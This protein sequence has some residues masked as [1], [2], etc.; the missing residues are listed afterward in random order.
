MAN[1]FSGTIL[2]L[3]T[4]LTLL[5][6]ATYYVSSSGDDTNAGTDQDAPWQNCPG[7]P[8][9]SGSA[10][11]Q[12]G[13]TV[14]FNNTDTWEVSSGSA[15]LQVTGGVF[16]DGITWGSGSRAIF[17]AKADLNR[18]V[19]TMLKD[20]DKIHTVVKGFEVDAGGTVTTG[21]GMNHPQMEN[22]LLGKT[23]RIEDCIV[24]DVMSSSA[25]GTYKYGI[26]ISNRGAKYQ[27]KNVEILNCK[28]YNISRG[29]INL[30]PGNDTGANWVE[31]VLVRGN[32][33][34]N[35]GMDPDYGGS[36]L[37]VKN[38]VI[39]AVVEYNYVHDP[40]RGI[41]IGIS[42]HPEPGFTGPENLIIRHNIIANSKHAGM[43][44]QDGGDKSISIYGNIIMNSKY[45]GIILTEDL[46]GRLSIQIYNNTLYNNYTES[47][48]SAQIRIL[49]KDASITSLDV[50]NNLIYS[51]G[52]GRALLDDYGVVKKHMNNCYYKTQGGNLVIA[53][54]KTYTA[55]DIS[56][57]EP[58]AVTDDPL[59]FNPAK[60][61]TGFTGT[62]NVDMKPNTDGLNLT[63]N[64]P[65]KDYGAPIGTSVRSSINTVTRPYG[66]GWDIGAYEF[67]GVLPVKE[68]KELIECAGLQIVNVRNGIR[69]AFN[70]NLKENPEIWIYNLSGNAIVQL[71][72]Q[73]SKGTVFWDGNTTMGMKCAT[74]CYV[75]YVQSKTLKVSKH[76]LLYHRNR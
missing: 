39:D 55:A 61:P 16:Y 6:S 11:L 3:L 50:H 19:I 66:D 49:C 14:F 53:D 18:S 37:A 72:N 73:T 30:Y 56:K 62:W 35:A 71:S 70:G 9:W 33:C 13:D 34:R 4:L 46:T 68:K 51:T 42:N 60:P 52:P 65:A 57:W 64:S 58:Y 47:E 67:N 48:W 27:V 43:Y 44:I 10:T 45:Q 38:H 17:R 40:A 29:C 21:I 5:Y 26:V 24:H 59:L 23:K 69:F 8:G 2:I 12:A 76:F 41:G 25:Q 74:G 31:D 22:T 15:V 7:M 36:L 32:E 63:E 75:V 54:G 28:V 20:H 1:K